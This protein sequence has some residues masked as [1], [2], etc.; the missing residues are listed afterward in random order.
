M[1]FIRA[2]EIPPRSGNWYDYE[3]KSVRHG[4]KVSQEIIRYIGP[5]KRR[6][7]G[8][9]VPNTKSNVDIK[10]EV[11][12]LSDVVPNI[13]SITTKQKNLIKKIKNAKTMQGKA[14]AWY[15]ADLTS[16]GYN[17]LVQD[18]ILSLPEGYYKLHDR[19]YGNN[20]QDKIYELYGNNPSISVNESMM[21]GLQAKYPGKVYATFTH[22]LDAIEIK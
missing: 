10:G 2:K 3:V 4:N 22:D 6:I 19:T 9:V 15:E 7:S 5:S 12:T 21:L 8:N 13:P 16:D 14:D 20:I 1:S 17:K 18:M 11:K